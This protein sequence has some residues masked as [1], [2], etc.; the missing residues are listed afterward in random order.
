LILR[1]AHGKSP[2][3]YKFQPAHK[4][5]IK[6]TIAHSSNYYSFLC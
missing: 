6:A 2:F 3:P 5:L 1:A 4:L